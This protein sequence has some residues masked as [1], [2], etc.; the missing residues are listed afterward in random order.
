MTEQ[1]LTWTVWLD[2]NFCSLP[3]GCKNHLILVKEPVALY[4]GL[5]QKALAQRYKPKK[6]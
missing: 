2:V 1:S 6:V 3:E 4:E 5:E